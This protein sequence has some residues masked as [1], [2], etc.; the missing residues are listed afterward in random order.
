MLRAVVRT[1]LLP[2]RARWPLSPNGGRSL[3]E[4]AATDAELL[5]SK[6]SGNSGPVT[7]Y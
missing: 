1:A 7:D 3:A 6:P 5:Q 4:R 2:L